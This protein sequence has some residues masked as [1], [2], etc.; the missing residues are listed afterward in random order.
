MQPGEVEH[1]IGSQLAQKRGDGL[2][3]AHVQLDQLYRNGEAFEQL[4]SA[5][6]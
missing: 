2:P 4:G 3:L 5:R 6:R 1:P